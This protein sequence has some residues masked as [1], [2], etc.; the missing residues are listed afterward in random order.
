ML[1]LVLAFG[2][3]SEA[4]QN[5]SDTQQTS[6]VAV[7]GEQAPDF[8]LVDTEGNSH[9]LSDFAGKYVVLEWVNFD[10]PFVKAHYSSGNFPSMQADYTGQGAI[11]L[12][13]CSSAPGKQGHFTGDELASRMEQAGWQGTAYLIDDSGKVGRLY[14]AKTTPHM[15]LI[16]PE[17]MLVYAGAINSKPSTDPEDIPDATNYV[18]AA[19]AAHRSG[20]PVA[21]NVTAPYGCSV[22]Y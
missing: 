6:Q 17:G 16:S 22:K 9:S 15:Y 1:A 8:T 2:C 19:F 4:D 20:E 18:Q 10:C 11:W 13:I 21:P 12:S 7:V 3:S 14:E 5:Q